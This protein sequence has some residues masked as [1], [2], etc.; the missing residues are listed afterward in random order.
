MRLLR[1]VLTADNYQSLL[2]EFIVSLTLPD[3][4]P[5]AS[6]VSFQH[7]AEDA[8]DD[9]VRSAVD[10][11]GYCARAVPEST[12]QCLTALMSFIQSKNGM[13]DR[14]LSK[15]TSLICIFVRCGR[16]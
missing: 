13:C 1:T 11:I 16:G 5:P 9:L 14:M 7:Y 6:D 10:A 15:N 2:R 12:Q 8:D 3:G 4:V